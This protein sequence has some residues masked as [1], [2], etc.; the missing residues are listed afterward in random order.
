MVPGLDPH[1]D[2][3]STEVENR[4]DLTASNAGPQ[5]VGARQ[6]TIKYAPLVTDSLAKQIAE[7]IRGAIA[8]GSLKADD[9]LPT[10]E[11]LA[12][13]FEVSRP[14]I[15]EALKRLAAQ[16]LI[17][18]RRGPAGG[19]FVNRPDREE[20]GST[21]ATALALLVG[22]GEFGLP[23][24]LEARDELEVVCAR[25]AAERREDA[26][27]AIMAKEI[28]V[29]TDAALS[30][31]DFCASDVRFHRALVDSTHNPVIQFVMF[32]VIE[33]LQPIENMVVVR[34]R[35]RQAIVA[36]HQRLFQAVKARDAA[37]AIAAI[38]EQ[39]T[40]LREAF[41]AAQEKRRQREDA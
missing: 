9:R 7:S 34:F 33:A 12:R 20:V 3:R 15:R 26:E 38:S 27:L 10:E 41:A 36:Q 35:D 16:N 23:D 24:V 29:Q 31:E 1:A 8:D 32:A 22:L 11:E 18:S 5:D 28:E 4:F 13:R 2:D 37:A 39:M 21:L 30:D 19:T 40:Y 14:T 6:M 25:L 17:R